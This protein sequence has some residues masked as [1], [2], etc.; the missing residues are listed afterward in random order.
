LEA[1]DKGELPISRG[2]P[3]PCNSCLIMTEALQNNLTRTF[4]GKKLKLF[5]Y[6]FPHLPLGSGD[7]FV[8]TAS[9]TLNASSSKLLL[10]LMALLLL[11]TLATTCK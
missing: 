6:G 9:S 3:T 2:M 11:N 8:S 10:Y 4:P 7:V 5:Q 1:T